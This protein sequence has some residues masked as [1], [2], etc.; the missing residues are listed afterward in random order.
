MPYLHLPIQSGSDRI[1][2]L[3]N[4]GHSVQFYLEIIK[5]LRILRPDIAIS[6][7]F[8]VGFPGETAEDFRCTLDVCDKIKYAQA[9]SFKYS[10]RVGTPAFE[11]NDL[12]EVIK[13]KRLEKLQ[14]KIQQHQ[15]E[16][17][18]NLIGTVQEILIE[19]YGKKNQQYIGRSP[20]M[21]PVVIYSNKNIMGELVRVKINGTNGLSLSAD[22]VEEKFEEECTYDLE[23][24]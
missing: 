18:Q 5:E 24:L 22:L 1:L 10:P 15:I 20:Y 7:D 8:I 4:R 14:H 21:N 19:K 16:F 11:K 3:M 6:G 13:S 17:H 9:Y 2:K 12:S 23:S